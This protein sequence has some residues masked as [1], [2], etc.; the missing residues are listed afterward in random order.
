MKE[1]RERRNLKRLEQK[2]LAMHE[3]IDRKFS[4]KESRMGAQLQLNDRQEQIIAAALRLLDA[5]GLNNLSLRKLAK[6]L[7]LQAPALYW[8]FKN[9]EVLIDYMAEAILRQEFADLQAR[10]DTETW[11]DWLMQACKRLRKAMLA[12]R[13]GAR[14]VAGAHFYPAVTL[15]KFIEVCEESLVS[16]GVD[17]RH[18]D[19]V[20]STAIHFTFGRVIEEQA[21]P[22][23]EQIE[24]LDITSLA[25]QYPRLASSI[26]RTMQELAAGYDE[27]D[28]ALRL[29]VGTTA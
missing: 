21:G 29:I 24:A 2:R 17:E 25:E 3:H 28:S 12:H 11:Q 26:A 9:K 13:D 23:L 4:E 7:D 22:S 1:A 14:I 6:L 10:L 20:V 27:F 19:L 16:A 8:H 15:M 18:T 5:E